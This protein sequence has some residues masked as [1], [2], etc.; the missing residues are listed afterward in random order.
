[1]SLISIG[2]IPTRIEDRETIITTNQIE[3]NRKG[4]AENW[5][6]NKHRLRQFSQSEDPTD[7]LN[8][9]RRTEETI[10]TRQIK[11]GER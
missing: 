2:S 10:D 6:T 1:M 3:Q 4:L 7:I 9:Q 11:R 8:V 5:S